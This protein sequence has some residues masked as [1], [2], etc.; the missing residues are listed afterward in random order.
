M[1]T[2]RHK[3]VTSIGVGVLW[4]FVAATITAIA[5]S[6]ATGLPLS[7]KLALG[8]YLR[9]ADGFYGHT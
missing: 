3:V 8:A 6:F 4:T 5:L 7:P 2:L 9:D 1:I